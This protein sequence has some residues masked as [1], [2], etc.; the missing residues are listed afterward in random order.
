M[1]KWVADMYNWLEANMLKVTDE[2]TEVIL[3]TPKHRALKPVDVKG[4]AFVIRSA[5]V[6]I[7]I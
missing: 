4:G 5:P 1:E 3:F 2:K 6:V 7:N